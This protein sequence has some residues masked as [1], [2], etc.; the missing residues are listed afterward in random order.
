VAKHITTSDIY[1][2]RYY[3]ILTH[4]TSSDTCVINAEIDDTSGILLPVG[5]SSP[6]DDATLGSV[7]TISAEF[8]DFLAIALE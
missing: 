4:L 7:S 3:K 5:S 1:I 8:E 6:S 2:L